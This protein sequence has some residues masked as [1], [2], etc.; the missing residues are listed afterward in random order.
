MIRRPLSTRSHLTYNPL[1]HGSRWSRGF[2]YKVLSELYICTLQDQETGEKCMATSS[3]VTCERWTVHHYIAL[4][5]LPL[6]KR[7]NSVWY[8]NHQRTLGNS[9]GSYIN[10]FSSGGLVHLSESKSIKLGVRQNVGSRTWACQKIA[11]Q[12]GHETFLVLVRWYNG[13]VLSLFPRKA[14][15]LVLKSLRERVA[16]DSVHQTTV[17]LLP[18]PIDTK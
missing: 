2:T 15:R 17:N 8:C 1:P 5:P 7:S 3:Q 18:L 4:A 9:A 16:T 11:I 13:D 12:C 6:D 14:L 10:F